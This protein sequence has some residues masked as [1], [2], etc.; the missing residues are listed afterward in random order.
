MTDTPQGKLSTVGTRR[1]P[2]VN[3]ETLADS[4]EGGGGGVSAY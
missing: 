4:S 3:K 1:R 2:D